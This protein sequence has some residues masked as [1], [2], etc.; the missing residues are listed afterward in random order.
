MKEESGGQ[1]T[2]LNASHLCMLTDLDAT[3]SAIAGAG[4]QPSRN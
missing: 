2:T 4:G 1:I 3:V